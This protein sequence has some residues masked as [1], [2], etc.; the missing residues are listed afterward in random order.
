MTFSD[1][2]A[3]QTGVVQDLG[4]GAASFYGHVQMM[5]VGLAFCFAVMIVL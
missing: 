5:G 3:G 1:D 4:S 2:G